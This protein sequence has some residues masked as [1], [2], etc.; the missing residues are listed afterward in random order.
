MSEPELEK[1]P[2]FSGPFWDKVWHF[3]LPLFF[4]L[5]GFLFLVI[6]FSLMYKEHSNNQ[7][8]VVEHSASVS[9]NIVFNVIKVDIEGAVVNPGVYE[10]KKD[11]RV[12]NLIK[13]AGGILK[14]ADFSWIKKNLNLAQKLLDGTKIYVPFQGETSSSLSNLSDLSS[15]SNL[16]GNSVVNLNTASLSDLDTLP[17]VGPAT[18]QK[19]IDGRPY[20]K[21]EDLVSKK[22]VGQSVYEKIKEKVTVY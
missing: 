14:N 18:A 7:S 2:S 20:E 4:F 16:K 5:L 1:N 8:V 15:L 21:P 10:L 6:S 13:K 3:R 11:D 22:A 12:E 19:I 17:G 9:A